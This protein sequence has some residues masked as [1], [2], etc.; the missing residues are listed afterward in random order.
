MNRR[1]R[2]VAGD[3]GERKTEDEERGELD[4]SGGRHRGR[5]HGPQA[6]FFSLQEEQTGISGR[7][8]PGVGGMRI[9]WS[10]GA[11][12]ARL[13]NVAGIAPASAV[14][15]DERGG[16]GR[17]VKPAAEV[18]ARCTALP[19]VVGGIGARRAPLP[20][21]QKGERDTWSRDMMLPRGPGHGRMIEPARGRVVA[22]GGVR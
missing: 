4:W 9:G 8:V 11:T 10:G 5:W 2:K 14:N 6:P 21:H 1:R 3:R 19:G 17:A 22:Y 18:R 20:L 16:G 7:S 12:S 15:D 13:R